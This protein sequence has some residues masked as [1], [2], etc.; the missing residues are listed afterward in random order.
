MMMRDDRND[1]I[2]PYSRLFVVCSKHLTIDDLNPVFLKF[3]AVERMHMPKDRQT[4]ESKGIAYV[5]YAKTSSAAAAIEALHMITL[6][7]C[8]KPLKVMLSSNKNEDNNINDEK[9]RRLFIKVD[10]EETES[11][12]LNNFS[13]FGQIS[14]VYLQKDRGTGESRGFAYVL[15]NSFQEAAIA[16]EECDKRYKAIFATPKDELKRA[17]NSYDISEGSYSHSSYGNNWKDNFIP[18]PPHNPIDYHRKDFG[19]AIIPL[20]KNKTATFDTVDVTCSPCMP[21]RFLERL[22]SVIPGMKNCKF[23]PDPY[24]GFC[25]ALITY[26][27]TAAAAHAVESFDNFEF[28]SGEI[29]TVKPNDPISK[30]ANNISHLVNSFKNSTES[31]NLMQLA[32]AIE[33]ASSL[34]KAATTGKDVKLQSY[35]DSFCS[36]RLPP[37]QPLADRN[38]KVAQRCFLVFK[39]TPPPLSALEDVFSRFGDLIDVTTYPRKTFGFVRYASQRAAQDAIATL[40]GA[41]VCDVKLKVLEATEKENTDTDVDMESK[42]PKMNH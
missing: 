16:H 25:K 28:P 34:L 20:L 33:Q 21:P 11:E 7:K 10:K 18:E 5:K 3:G 31:P 26:E 15:F 2:P 9:F 14:A 4:G 17:R 23:S 12:I 42:R 30:V 32:D 24:N 40:H 19:N 37:Q 8:D 35:N 36:V 38:S 1:E 13:Q 29:I 39:P 22:F 41:F 6:D 27:T